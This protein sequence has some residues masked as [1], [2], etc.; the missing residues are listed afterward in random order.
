[1]AN[2]ITYGTFDF[3]HEGHLRILERCR[4]LAGAEGRLFVGVTSENYDRERGKLNV[5]ESLMTRIDHIRESGLVDDVFVEEYE[6]QKI[7]DIQRYNIDIFAIGSDWTGKYDYLNEWCKVVYLPRTQGISSTQIRNAESRILRAGIV[8]CGRIAERFVN[9]AHFVSGVNFE[10]VCN[11]DISLAQN[12]CGKTGIRSAYSSF[13][14]ML[15]KVDAVYV[16][17][18]HTFH[19]EY[20]RRALIAGRHVL[21]EKPFTLNV[22]EAKELYN[23][24]AEKGMVLQEALKTAFAPGF[25][26]LVQLAK[27]GVVGKIRQVRASFTKLEKDYSLR[28]F[29]AELGGGCVSELA[30]YVLCPIVKILGVAETDALH[31]HCLREPGLNVET[32]A[33]GMIEYAEATATFTVGLTAKTEGDLIVAGSQGYIYV[34]SPWWKTDYFE[35]RN[36]MGNSVRRFYTPFAG[37]GLRYELADWLTAIKTKRASQCWTAN[38]S[39][40]ALSFLTVMRNQDGK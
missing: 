35:I 9:E 28:E 37:D 6:G 17:T 39:L 12:F 11:P 30:S 33:T 20:A 36:D 21:C 4:K 19:A 22:E 7:E 3:F 16:A 15:E 2:V 23:L 14:E 26:R 13:D 31:V 34:P 1:M 5:C 10:A 27:G 32:F 25:R 38:D 18:P 29:S 40:T 8:G 24:A